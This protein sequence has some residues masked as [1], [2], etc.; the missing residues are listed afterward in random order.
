MKLNDENL[1]ESELKSFWY[2]LHKKAFVQKWTWLYLS[3]LLT[4]PDDQKPQLN[5][6]NVAT[7][8]CNTF[9]CLTDCN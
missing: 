6:I 7:R 9:D 2:K 1:S 5:V 4:T 8:V 3:Q